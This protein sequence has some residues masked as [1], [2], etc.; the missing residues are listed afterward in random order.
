MSTIATDLRA[1]AALLRSKATELD[2][3]AA[4]LE[5]ARIDP[6]P[7][8]GDERCSCI[9]DAICAELGLTAA[10]VRSGSRIAS[11]VVARDIITHA[12]RVLLGLDFTL[13]AERLGLTSQSS[14][15]YAV[16]RVADRRSI[17]NR[18]AADLARAMQA[19]HAALTNLGI[20][21]DAQATEP[22]LAR[23]G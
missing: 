8:G 15:R 23:V 16:R 18:Y 20:D 21:H 3:I 2:A 19:A 17:D 10:S 12:W 11:V 7:F 5:A 4:D 13:I 1:K 22:L 14:C 9:A 6:V